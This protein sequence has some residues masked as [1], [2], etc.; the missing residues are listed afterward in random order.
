MRTVKFKKWIPTQYFQEEGK[1]FKERVKGTGKF[2][3][4]FIHEGKFHQWATNYEEGVGNFTVA[5]IELEDGTIEE[6]TPN[7]LKFIDK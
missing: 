1:G 3:D 5:L 6:V 2:E 4:E 7:N